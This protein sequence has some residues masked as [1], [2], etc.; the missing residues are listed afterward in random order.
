MNWKAVGVVAGV[1]AVGFLAFKRFAPF[2]ASITPLPDSL[3]QKMIG[4]SWHDGC[5]VPLDA[6]AL[7]KVRYRANSGFTKMGK[8]I[9]AADV[10][11]SLAGA[12][13]EVYRQGFRIEKIQPVY[14][15]GGSDAD[16]MRANNTS[17]FNC[18]RST[19]GSKWSEHSKGLAIDINPVT[20]PYVSSGGSVQPTEGQRYTDRSIVVKGTVTPEIAAIF[21]RYGW[22]WGGD[23]SSAKDYQHFSTT[24][25]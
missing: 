20:N 6:L 18:R 9:I 11:E 7:L 8:L 1:G 23:W 10:A 24:G 22:Q 15:F 21:G 12:L 5:P 13:E 3:K 4:V 16:S 2:T 14:K 17:A 19:G 25:R